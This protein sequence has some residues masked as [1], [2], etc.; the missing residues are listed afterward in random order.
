VLSVDAL[1]LLPPL[2]HD[3][4]SIELIAVIIIKVL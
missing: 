4:I 2:E 3:I 1:T